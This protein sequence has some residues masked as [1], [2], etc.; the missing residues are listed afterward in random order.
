MKQYWRRPFVWWCTFPLTLIARAMFTCLSVE[1]APMNS[2]ELRFVQD[3]HDWA[4][5]W[6]WSSLL[7]LAHC[8]EKYFVLW[9]WRYRSGTVALPK[10]EF[11]GKFARWQFPRFQDYEWEHK[12]HWSSERQYNTILY[13]TLAKSVIVVRCLFQNVS[14]VSFVKRNTILS[15]TVKRSEIKGRNRNIPSRDIWN[16]IEKIQKSKK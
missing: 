12:R 6:S 9:Y 7:K 3:R 4:K 5:V 2:P 8:F 10:A 13:N 16:K 1:M 11:D 15:R 14:V